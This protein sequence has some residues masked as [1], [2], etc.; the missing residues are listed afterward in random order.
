MYLFIVNYCSIHGFYYTFKIFTYPRNK[1]RM[2]PGIFWTIP[3]YIFLKRSNMIVEFFKRL[4]ERLRNVECS[5]WEG[6]HSSTVESQTRPGS[7]ERDR[8]EACP[9]NH[10]RGI[11]QL[12]GGL[13]DINTALALLSHSGGCVKSDH[14]TE[15]SSQL[16]NSCKL[17]YRWEE[18][19]LLG[20]KQE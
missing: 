15:L 20:S 7:L 13:R 4:K 3:L 11:W 14:Q 1:Y 18:E 19:S 5:M 9:L 2:Q 12:L 8:C 16:F 17:H 6:F 10:R